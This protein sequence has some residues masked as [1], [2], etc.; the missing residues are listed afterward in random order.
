MLYYAASTGGFYDNSVHTAGQ[1]PHDAV[2]IT[3]DR[4]RA[5]LAAQASGKVISPDGSGHPIATDPPGPTAAQ[6]AAQLAAQA[7]SLL[8]KSDVT[9]LRCLENGVG[10]PQAWRDYRT[11]L[12]NVVSGSSSTIPTRPQYPAGT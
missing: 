3:T 6:L 7:Q 12:R 8:D 4:H 9:L 11:A 2:V 10:V 5:L 1:I